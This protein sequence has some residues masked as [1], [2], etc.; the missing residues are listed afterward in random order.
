VCGVGTLM[1]VCGNNNSVSGGAVNYSTALVTS[2]S[3][4]PTLPSDFSCTTY[5]TTSPATGDKN[6]LYDVFVDASGNA[7]YVGLIYHPI[8]FTNK[9]GLILAGAVGTVIEADDT[10]LTL[11]GGLTVTGTRQLVK[12]YCSMTG[13]SVT[14]QVPTIILVDSSAG[15]AKVIEGYGSISTPG[16]TNDADYVYLVGY[17]YSS[18]DNYVDGRLRAEVYKLS[19]NLYPG[20]HATIPRGKALNDSLFGNSKWVDSTGSITAV[21]KGDY[22]CDTLTGNFSDAAFSYIAS[23]VHWIK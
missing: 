19:R 16:L 5:Y 20:A 8:T 22:A 21:W 15:F 3:N 9:C 7:K 1:R 14:F 6:I 18:F 11:E 17:G 23:D 10:D 12:G 2:F 13:K 4:P